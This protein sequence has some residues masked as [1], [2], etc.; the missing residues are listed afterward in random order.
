MVFRHPSEKYEVVSGDDDIPNRW[1][2]IKVMFQ[3]T[4]QVQNSHHIRPQ[5]LDASGCTGT[6]LIV[7]NHSQQPNTLE[8][9]RCWI[10][11]RN[12]LG[13]LTSSA[14][15]RTANSFYRHGRIYYLILV[16]TWHSM[17]ILMLPSEK[18]VHWP[19]RMATPITI[20]S[21][22]WWIFPISGV[23][24][25]LCLYYIV[26]TIPIFWYPHSVSYNQVMF[27]CWRVSPG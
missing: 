24:S 10:A 15:R 26:F 19:S 25:V 22:T 5:N 11:V 12:N 2:V 21:P 27:F 17:A 16:K 20:Y 18:I 7:K 3:T 6:E 23:I 4:N 8:P 13:V 1:K 9:V 14:N